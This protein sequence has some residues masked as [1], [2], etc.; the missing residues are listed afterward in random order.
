VAARNDSTGLLVVGHGTRHEQG[1]LDFWTT[2][3]HVAEQLPHTA[4][5]GCFLEACAPDL[6]TAVQAMAERG[7]RQVVLV[8]LLLF[9]A[10]HARRDIPAAAS[11]AAHLTGVAVRQA[12]VLGCHRRLVELSA[13]RFMTA[14]AGRLAAEKSLLLLVGRGSR[15]SAA[16]TEMHRF[17]ALRAELTPVGGIQVAFL[18]MARP[19]V[20]EVVEQIGETHWPQVVVQPH[21]LYPG[22]LAARL[23]R[24][25]RLQDQRPV[26]QRWIMGAGL[27]CDPVVA[28]VVVER[29]REVV[30]EDLRGADRP[31]IEA[32]PP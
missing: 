32:A 18:S 29:F 11:R 31:A 19:R 24:L 23:E 14:T 17:A 10:G 28:Q 13:A 26:R 27:G 4:V 15:D 21:L 5:D 1:R 2:V 25:V 3:G 22:A 7:I 8:P 6:V 20:E 9:A 12:D 30:A 16:T